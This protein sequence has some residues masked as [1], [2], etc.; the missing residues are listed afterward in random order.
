MESILVDRLC[1]KGVRT[2]F[3]R[4]PSIYLPTFD[5]EG[6]ATPTRTMLTPSNKELSI[7]TRAVTE[8]GVHDNLAAWEQ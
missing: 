5:A 8:P 1:A 2:P 7:C 4:K 3:S 6:V